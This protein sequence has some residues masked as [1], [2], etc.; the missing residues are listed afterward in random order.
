MLGDLHVDQARGFQAQR[1]FQILIGRGDRLV[2]VGAVFGRGS[3]PH[4]AVGHNLVLDL[5][6]IVGLDEVHVFQQVSH[7]G[8]AIA[9]VARAHLDNHVDRHLRVGRVRIEQDAQTVGVFIFGDA[10]DGS[11]LLDSGR[12]CLADGRH[13]QRENGKQFETHRLKIRRRRNFGGYP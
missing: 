1:P 12:Q 11:L 13:G 3:I 9:F 10:P 8:L 4:R 5:P 6:A 2:V 7:A